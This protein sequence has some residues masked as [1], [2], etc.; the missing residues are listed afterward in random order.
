M[1]GG[2]WKSGRCQRS[3]FS[4]VWIYRE[5]WIVMAGVTKISQKKG[6][7]QAVEQGFSSFLANIWHIWWFFKVFHAWNTIA[8]PKSRFLGIW[9]Q[10]KIERQNG[11]DIL[12]L[13]DTCPSY[14]WAISSASIIDLI[15]TL[16]KKL[17]RSQTFSKIILG[18]LANNNF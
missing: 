2:C 13:V 7:R 5:L 3:S 14:I 18:R 10:I 17:K 12:M 11:T 15:K 4:M 16:S 9:S 1:G 6:L 8:L